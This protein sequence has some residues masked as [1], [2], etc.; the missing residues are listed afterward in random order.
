[1]L[2]LKNQKIDASGLSY[3]SKSKSSALA[4]KARENEAAVYSVQGVC[5]AQFFSA[6]W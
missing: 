6:L 4:Q 1:M 2:S 3:P 5:G